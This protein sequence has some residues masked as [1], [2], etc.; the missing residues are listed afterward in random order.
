MQTTL[1]PML[2]LDESLE[3][4]RSAWNSEHGRSSCWLGCCLSC[5]AVSR[6][7]PWSR[8]AVGSELLLPTL[9]SSCCGCCCWFCTCCCCCGCCGCC[10]WAADTFTS[11]PPAKQQKDDM[12]TGYRSS[13]IDGKC[14]VCQIT[15]NCQIAMPFTHP[16]PGSQQSSL[17]TAE[18]LHCP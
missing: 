12:H 13:H 4:T 9:P 17:Q 18:H 16:A 14:D 10:C 3:M 8:E 11:L 7:E 15:A 5:C 6:A 1:M 2:T